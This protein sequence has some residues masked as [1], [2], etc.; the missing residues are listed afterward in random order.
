VISL[1]GD[2]ARPGNYEVPIGFPLRELLHDVAG[3][4]GAGRTVQ[5]VT[6][7]GLSG[8]SSAATTST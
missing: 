3:G 6:M 1:S 4:P 2:V 7:A 8:A 5:A